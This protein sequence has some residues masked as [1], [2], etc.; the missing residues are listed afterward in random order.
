MN[1][2]FNLSQISLEPE[3]SRKEQLLETLVF[4]FLI[5]P[6]MILSFIVNPDQE[7]INFSVTAL[8]LIF[9]DLALVA[10]VG[11]L[12]WRNSESMRRIGWKTK[13]LFREAMLG[14]ALFFPMTYGAAVLEQI[15]ES[16]GLTVPK[17]HLPSFLSPK[18]TEQYILAV[19]L[20][21]V[22][23]IAEETI[24]RGYL[25]LR[26]GALL[27]NKVWAVLLATVVFAIG[28]GYEG[29]AGVATVYTMGLVF[30]VVYL[31][32]KSLVAPMVMHFMQDFVGI[33]VLPLL[34]TK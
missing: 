23:A 30:S 20:V 7:Q 22:V 12:L 31:W 24:F 9:N 29:T 18:T 27:R 10:L 11:F 1:N 15:F 13:S 26:F 16:A 5:V 33:V 6:G 34:M 17:T 3:T 19:F 25:I 4:C 8:A 14:F 28:H 32:R 2:E 21:V